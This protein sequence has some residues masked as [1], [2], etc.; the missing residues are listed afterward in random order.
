MTMY[1]D[2]TAKPP[3]DD[4][5]GE[6]TLR[7]LVDLQRIYMK[8]VQDIQKT[9][10]KRVEGLRAVLMERNVQR[11]EHVGAYIKDLIKWSEEK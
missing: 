3:S 10:D 6:F 9:L 5:Y 8:V 2:H 7:E 11:D 1:F 4:E